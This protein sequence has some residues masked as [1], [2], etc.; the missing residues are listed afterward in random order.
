MTSFRIVT[1]A[2]ADME[3]LVSCTPAAHGFIADQKGPAKRMVAKNVDLELLKSK[4]RDV[5]DFPQPGVLFRDITQLLADP[6]VFKLAID[7]MADSYQ[8][9]SHVVAIESRGF[10]L[11]APLAYSIGA[12]LILVRKVGKLPAETIREDYGL[13]YGN[14]TVEM[15]TDAIRPGERVL[16]VDDVLATG[17]TLRA[18]ANLVERLGAT[19]AGISLLIELSFLAGRDRLQEYPVSSVITY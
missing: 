19:V 14:N 3:Q 15:Q 11:G 16:I 13:E 7:A 2:R 6:V 9:I 12:G 8:G 10:I 5:P 18:A 17:G 4:I 1:A